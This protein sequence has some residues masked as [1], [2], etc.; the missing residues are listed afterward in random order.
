M[1][2]HAGCAAVIADDADEIMGV[3]DR[4]QLAHAAR[5]LRTRINLQLMLSGVTL[6]D[7]DQTYVDANVQVGTDTIIWPGCVLRGNTTIG[8]CCELESNVQVTSCTV[9]DRVHLK[10]GSVLSEAQVS[11]DVSIG[12]MAHLRPGTVLA[13]PSQDR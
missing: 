1:A 9:A 6:V 10:A 2:E 4:V 7:P 13:G 12:P 11:E 5:I 3:N 8:S